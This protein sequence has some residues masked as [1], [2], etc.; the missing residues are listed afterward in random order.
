V[1]LCL[2]RVQ[3]GATQLK[4]RR[5]ISCCSRSRCWLLMSWPVPLHWTG[6]ADAD[7]PSAG[8][9]DDGAWFRRAAI[10]PGM[11]P[12]LRLG[13]ASCR[14]VELRSTFVRRVCLMLLNLVFRLIR[15]VSVLIMGLGIFVVVG[16]LTR[17]MLRCMEYVVPVA[18]FVL[19]IRIEHSTLALRA[20][21]SRYASRSHVALP[22][23]RACASMRLPFATLACCRACALL[24]LRLAFVSR[25]R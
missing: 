3:V 17:C 11:P 4:K 13:F 18:V 14:H 10:Q 22:L 5:H 9:D 25:S 12:S 1:L 21:T 8:V 2:I 16:L 20:C 7:G 6:I 23:C 19:C 24:R 15:S